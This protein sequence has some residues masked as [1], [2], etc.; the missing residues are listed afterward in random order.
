VVPRGRALGS[1]GTLVGTPAEEVNGVV[2]VHGVAPGPM[3]R[4]SSPISV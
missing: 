4:M 2:G 1:S 3:A